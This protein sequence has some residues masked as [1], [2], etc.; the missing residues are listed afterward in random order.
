MVS[1]KN[2]LIIAKGRKIPFLH[3]QRINEL[4]LIAHK[5]LKHIS[6]TNHFSC[7]A[8]FTS[9]SLY[10]HPYPFAFLPL[11]LSTYLPPYPTASVPIYPSASLP[12]ASLSLYPSATIPHYLSASVPICLLTPLPLCLPTPL[13][14]YFYTSLPLCPSQPPLLALYITSLSLSLSHSLSLSFPFY[15]TLIEIFLFQ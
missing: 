5:D 14:A 12:T 11:C 13:P 6:N 7:R 2:D 4:I 15:I 1:R 9:I 10:V 3:F 8:H